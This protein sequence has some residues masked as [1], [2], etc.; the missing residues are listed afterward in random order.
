MGPGHPVLR[1][2]AALR[3][4]PVRAPVGSAHR[5]TGPGTTSCCPPR[6]AV[7]CARAGRT[8]RPPTIFTDVD[9]ARAAVRL[10]PR[11]RPQ[12]DRGEPRAVG[13]PIG[14]TWCSS[15]IPTTTRRRPCDA[16]LPDAAGAPGRGRRRRG[17]LRHEPGGDAR[18]LRGAGR[19]RLRAARRALHVARTSRRRAASGRLPRP[20][21]SGW[22]S[23]ACS[24]AACWSTPTTRPTYEYAAA[25]E[26]V[27]E[28]ARA[29]RD[30]CGGPRRP[31]A[32]RRPAV[33]PCGTR[34]SPRCSSG[35]GRP[36]RSTSTSGTPSAPVA[37]SLWAELSTP[38]APA[39]RPGHRV[40]ALV[41]LA[42]GREREQGV[43]TV[44]NI[45]VVGGG[46][47]GLSTAMLL[48]GDGH[49]VTVLERDPAPPPATGDEAWDSWER[50][51]INQFHM[52]HYFLPRFR[53]VVEA[54][55]PAVVTAL[56]ADG[57]LRSNPIANAPHE[58]TGGPRPGDERFEVMT[59]RRP[60][61]E[62]AFARTA[63]VDAGHHRP[64]GRRGE[65]P[66]DRRT[67]G[68]RGPARRGGDHRRRVT[69][70]GP[71]WSSTRPVVARPSRPCSRRSAAARPVEEVEDSGFMYYGRHFRSKTGEL[72]PAFGPPLQHY[73]S[74][75][76]LTLPAD[77]GTWGMGLVTAA[78]DAD[79][80]RRQGR[81]DLGAD[82]LRL[83]ADRPLDRRGPAHRHPADGQDRGS[84]PLLRRRGA[85]RRDRAGAGR[86]LVGL[87]QS[88]GRS[89]SDDR[90]SPCRG[91][92]RP[93]PGRR[94]RGS[95]V[96]R[97]GLARGDSREGRALVPG[98]ARL[99]PQPPRRDR[100]PDRRGALRDRRHLLGRGQGHGGRLRRSGRPPGLRRDRWP[101]RHRRR[102]HGSPG[103][104]RPGHRALGPTF[105]AG[106]RPERGTELLALVQSA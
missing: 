18:A 35:P 41:R 16:G 55:L 86:R 65:G 103:L 34:P 20:R 67:I 39:T 57:V 50:R 38:S 61:V 104:L 58:V 102:D 100:S 52:I 83:S 88:V 3:P 46:M 28:Q 47:C 48:A 2:G 5:A 80:R 4:R 21:A 63:C 69:R 54:E 75:S 79:L 93:G 1:H 8:A 77:N 85:S 78:R 84:A 105:R 27:V 53:E 49:E 51:G 25:P 73:D 71:T 40:R 9:A 10:L 12:V 43:R 7:C 95:T 76:V 31:A 30:R 59:G 97:A 81:G 33:R 64:P 89:G 70:C 62:A 90:T 42:A 60:M 72:P 36:P 66:P 32:G 22:C 96:V 74:V 24:T 56:D 19:P 26:A 13:R 98:D 6:S 68:R 44:A 29:L 11:R 15:T 82:H 37:D 45:V 99:R 92:P 91:P 94:A 87:H 101:A 14:S 23:V 106:P 17:R